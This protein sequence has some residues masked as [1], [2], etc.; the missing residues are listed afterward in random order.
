MPARRDDVALSPFD[1]N[2]HTPIAVAARVPLRA[3]ASHETL[4]FPLGAGGL[5][6]HA[7]IPITIIE[8]VA[9]LPMCRPL[10]PRFLS[11]F[12]PSTLPAARAD[13][14]QRVILTMTMSLV[15]TF[16]IGI[17]GGRVLQAKRKNALSSMPT[18][19]IS[20]AAA[21]NSS[22]GAFAEIPMAAGM[23][24]LGRLPKN[25]PTIPPKRSIARVIKMAASPANN[26]DRTTGLSTKADY[27]IST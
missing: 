21:N 6:I 11:V 8:K 20:I 26:A 17:A 13:Q 9:K 22:D 27:S 5:R 3:R 10:I 1:I 14:T 2:T 23:M 18:G 7:H 25:P 24:V 15:R 16:A 12:T 4:F 19:V